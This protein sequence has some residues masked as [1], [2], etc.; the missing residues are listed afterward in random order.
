LEKFL[1]VNLLEWPRKFDLFGIQVSAT[2]YEEA[3]RLILAAAA[4]GKAA[5]VTQLSYEHA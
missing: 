3:A 2:D 4:A 5:M 1:T